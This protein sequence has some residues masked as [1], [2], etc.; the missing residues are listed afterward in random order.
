MEVITP[1]MLPLAGL[2]SEEIDRVVAQVPGGV[3]NIADV[4]PL[5]PAGGHPLPPPDGRLL[6]RRRLRTPDG[7]G[8]R[9]QGAAGRVRRRPPEGGGPARHPPYG[10]AVGGLREPVQVVSRHAEIPVREAALEHIAEGDVQGVVD[11]LLAAWDPHGH[12]RG[13][14]RAC[15]RGT[16]PR[17]H[18][19]RGP[20]TGA[21]PHPG[22]HRGGRSLRRSPGLLGGPR[23]RAGRSAAV[24]ELRRAGEARDPGGRAREV[25]H[26]PPR[27]C[28]GADRALRGA[29]CAGR[30]HRG[31]RVLRGSRPGDGRLRA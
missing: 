4:Y 8:L 12:H 24:P 3:G 27:R 2:S 19:M 9:L 25:L 10:C 14:A 13:P 17:H 22:P 26:H 30:W 21:S 15:H 18:P 5:A 6:G 31:G 23:G 20:R 16:G 28:H 7:P 11:G 29:G 1:E